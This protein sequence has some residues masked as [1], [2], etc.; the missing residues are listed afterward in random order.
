MKP[1]AILL[2][3]AALLSCSRK[4][5]PVTS[6][7]YTPR[8]T[9]AEE[10]TFPKAIDIPPGNTLIIKENSGRMI[11]EKA[12]LE[13]EAM[14]EG[15]AIPSF[16]RAVFITENAWFN[17]RL[18]YQIFDS[19]IDAIADFCRLLAATQSDSIDPKLSSY[20]AVYTWMHDSIRF[21]MGADTLLFKNIDYDFVDYAGKYDWANTFVTRLLATQKGTCRSMPYLYKILADKLELEAYLKLAPNHVY[22][23]HP[24]MEYLDHAFNKGTFKRWYNVELT[25][26]CFPSDGWIAGSAYISLDAIRSGLYVRRLKNNQD[27]NLCLLDLAQGYERKFIQRHIEQSET[28]L[29]DEAFL[30]KCINLALKHDKE[31]AQAKIMQAELL[32]KR[33]KQGRKELLPQM[34]EKYN[35]LFLEGYAEMPELM[36]LQWLYTMRSAGEKGILADT[37]RYFKAENEAYERQLGIPLMT[38]SD[39]RF[40]EV[41]D[42]SRVRRL[43]SVMLDTETGRIV[44]IINVDTLYSEASM[45][46]EILS[47]WLS[48]DPVTHPYESPY[49][50]MGNN[51]I[52]YADP[53]GRDIVIKNVT[54]EQAKAFSDRITS[55]SGI[56]ISISYEGNQAILKLASDY[57]VDAKSKDVIYNVF[58]NALSPKQSVLFQNDPSNVTFYDAYNDGHPNPQLIN[59]DQY[60]NTSESWFKYASTHAVTEYLKGKEHYNRTRQQGGYEAMHQKVLSQDLKVFAGLTKDAGLYSRLTANLNGEKLMEPRIPFSEEELSRESGANNIVVKYMRASL[61]INTINDKQ[62]IKVNYIFKQEYQVDSDGNEQPIGNRDVVG[63]Q[64]IESEGNTYQI[65]D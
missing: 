52:L 28:S 10:N 38:M 14:L 27:I 4:Q 19:R 23:Q 59:I 22:I 55:I 56:K 61:A 17:N 29:A 30:D 13:L 16:Q 51:P 47:R 9:Q 57:T 7:Q 58:A 46:P 40:K 36:Y 34:E 65:Q 5:Q 21:V 42:T 25:S 63:V 12:Y 43:G 45:A 60:N 39:G 20:W 31:S 2:T 54:E 53:D 49:V 62:L 3:L 33:Y 18:S 6:F 44:S 48:P 11:Y 1:L 64:S 41:P 37:N 24:K 8:Q 26:G 50:A 35:K 32:T 15:R